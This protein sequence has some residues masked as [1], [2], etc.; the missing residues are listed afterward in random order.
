MFLGTPSM[1]L[2]RCCIRDAVYEVLHIRGVTYKVLHTRCCIQR[3]STL[4]IFLSYHASVT[5]QH[6]LYSRDQDIETN[7]AE[8]R[9]I[10]TYIELLTTTC[11]IEQGVK[12]NRTAP[13]DTRS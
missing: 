12:M 4:L 13:D 11:Y 7:T 10:S 3:C 2:L 8:A 5:L 6:H 1:R 9:T